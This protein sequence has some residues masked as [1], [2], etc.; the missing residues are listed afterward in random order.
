MIFRPIPIRTTNSSDKL[1][2]LAGHLDVL[3]RDADLSYIWKDCEY[4]IARR[5]QVDCLGALWTLRTYGRIISEPTLT[6]STPPAFLS[7]LALLLNDYWS[8]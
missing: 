2:G 3:L 6:R 8:T 1:L 5:S 7:F 4:I